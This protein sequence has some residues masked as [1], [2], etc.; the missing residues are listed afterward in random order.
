[1]WGN[2]STDMFRTYPI[3]PD[4]DIEYAMLKSYEIGVTDHGN[5]ASRL[6]P[7]QCSHCWKINPLVS[8]NCFSFGQSLT[9]VVYTDDAIQESVLRDNPDILRQ[10]I[11]EK[12]EEMKRKGE[13]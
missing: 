7:V 1:M 3:S 6:E 5:S 11:D 13:I 2:I 9:D 12:I 8:N 4:R 10:L